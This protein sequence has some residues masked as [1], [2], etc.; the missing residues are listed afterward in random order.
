MILLRSD[1]LLSTKLGVFVL[2]ALVAQSL[3]I[4]SHDAD[5][6]IFLL[7]EL[8]HITSHGLQLLGQV[9]LQEQV[10]SQQQGLQQVRGS[11]LL[12]GSARLQ[13]QKWAGAQSARPDYRKGC[14]GAGDPPCKAQS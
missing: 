6:G 11:P 1:I 8:L 4:L 14:P 3:K 10:L 5:L 2:P 13:V 9:E 12:L 7:I